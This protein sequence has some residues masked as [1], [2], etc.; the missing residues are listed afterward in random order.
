MTDL[1]ATHRTI[2]AE[3]DCTCGHGVLDHS[4][5]AC[6]VPLDVWDHVPAKPCGCEQWRL[7]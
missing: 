4:D 6:S 2:L 1:D 3:L 7:G 5:G